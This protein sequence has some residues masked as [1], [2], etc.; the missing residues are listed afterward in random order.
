MNA[1]RRH[2]AQSAGYADPRDASEKGLSFFFTQLR[3]ANELGIHQQHR[4]GVEDAMQGIK[5]GRKVR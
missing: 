2:L 4:A 1:G 5:I 3:W